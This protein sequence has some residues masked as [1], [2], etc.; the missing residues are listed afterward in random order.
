M[1]K[2]RT[3]SFSTYFVIIYASS[4]KMSQRRMFSVHTENSHICVCSLWSQHWGCFWIQ[5]W[6]YWVDNIY[7]F[8]CQKE[9][10]HPVLNFFCF[11]LSREED[12]SSCQKE[13]DA[14]ELLVESLKKWIKETT[15]RIP[16]AQPSLNTEELKKPLEDT[17]VKY[18]DT[19]S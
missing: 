17:L 9:Y 18:C 13:M 14:F 6:H 4:I 10:W 15:E 2:H 5:E 8:N 3:A 12:V 1:D 7:W 16:A 19:S 11:Q